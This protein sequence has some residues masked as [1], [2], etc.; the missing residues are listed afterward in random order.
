MYVVAG[1]GFFRLGDILVHWAFVR[2]AAA[3]S[4]LRWIQVIGG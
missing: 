4:L 1:S 2:Q 3:I